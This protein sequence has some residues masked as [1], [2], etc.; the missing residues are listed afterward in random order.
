[1]I[2]DEGLARGRDDGELDRSAVQPVGLSGTWPQVARTVRIRGSDTAIDLPRAERDLSAFS[3]A[4]GGVRHTLESL[5]EAT[6]T[7]GIIVLRTA[8]SWRS[9]TWTGCGKTIDT[10]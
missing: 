6:A 9:G 4:R 8:P 2:D 5:L 7:D 10:S 3:F 1:M